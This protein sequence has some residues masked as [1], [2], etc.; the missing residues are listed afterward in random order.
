[1]L[2]VIEY[3]KDEYD[4]PALL[5]LGCFDAIHVGHRDLIKKAKLQ[6]KINGLDLGVMLFRDGKVG[7]TVYS[8]EERLAMLEEFN[9]KFVLV[10]DYTPEFKAT[11]PLDFLHI[12][13]EKV[14]VKA[15]MSGKDF[16][17]GANAKGKSSTIKS[18]AED[19][20][21]G[22]WYMPV[23]DVTIN[24]E[25][26]S[27]TLI[28]TYLENGDVTSA[29]EFLG[30]C[31]SVS[32]EVVKG[33]G[34]GASQLGYPTVNINYP[35]NKFSVKFGVYAVKSNIN[36]T[37]YY[38]IANYGTC[39]TFGD[40]RLAL[41]VHFEGIEGDL[42]GETLNIQFI[43][44]L[45]D[46]VAFASPEELIAQLDADKS[47]LAA[48]SAEQPEEP[49][50]AVAQSV[51]KPAVE[52]PVK[53][54]VAA[55]E[56]AEE[57]PAEPDQE[58]QETV[59]PSD[60][61]IA[62][63]ANEYKELV[64]GFDEL[65]E[66]Q[67]EEEIMPEEQ[68]EEAVGEPAKDIEEIAQP[69]VEETATEEAIQPEVTEEVEEIST[70][71]EQVIEET[72]E[73]ITEEASEEVSEPVNESV[74]EEAE[75]PADEIPAEQSEQSVEENYEIVDGGFDDIV[76]E[77]IENN[78]QTEEAQIQEELQVEESAEVTEEEPQTEEVAEVTEEEQQPEDENGEGKID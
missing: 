25:K 35:E 59:Q 13:E 14:N 21:N 51:P 5:V 12:V 40:D 57:V 45:R 72:V 34:R 10:I 56:V 65:A 74:E 71:P 36:G 69:T 70:E 63:S 61:E 7:K 62:I 22:V 53:E 48:I 78:A 39:P 23:K 67:P 15:Y 49:A 9:V 46:T 11:A 3:G 73:E 47:A 29:N 27:T 19:E 77:T 64:S 66:E 75:T 55:E 30:S 26:V 60:D 2:N 76:E 17:F 58:A 32:G 28:K 38:G 20:D 8:F 52:E 54:E 31:F 42:Y 4:F 50:E 41:E 33:E 68:P 44:Y 24:D 43:K 1:M 37:V 18:Y 16:R 6:A